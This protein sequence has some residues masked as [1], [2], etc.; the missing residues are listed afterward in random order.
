M[1]GARKDGMGALAR[2]LA[3]EARWRLLEEL[4]KGGIFS[5]TELAKAA[6]LSQPAA[7]LHMIRLR[8]AGIAVQ[9]KGRLYTLAPGVLA[10]G[11]GREVRLGI[12]TL[13]FGNVEH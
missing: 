9:G 8:K 1:K 4:S 10:E 5:V 11:E 12:C 7:S 6:G 3:S 13:D 2:L